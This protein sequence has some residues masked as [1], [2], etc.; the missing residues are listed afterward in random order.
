MLTNDTLIHLKIKLFVFGFSY[1]F[2]LLPFLHVITCDLLS[3]TI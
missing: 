2:Y 3:G 1:E